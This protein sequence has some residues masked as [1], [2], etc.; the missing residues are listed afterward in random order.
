M[1]K[2][3]VTCSLKTPNIRAAI[4]PELHDTR[5]IARW[6]DAPDVVEIADVQASIDA[7][8]Q[9]HRRQ[10]LVALGLPITAG[11][12]DASAP[13]VPHDGGD[14]RGLERDE[15]VLPAA[16]VKNAWETKQQLFAGIKA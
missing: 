4:L 9:S 11:A 14:H 2:L 15:L 12:R 6:V 16:F 8:C 1:H 7:P 3:G 10:Q 13:P 5:D